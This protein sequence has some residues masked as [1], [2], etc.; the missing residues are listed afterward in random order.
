MRWR[1]TDSRCTRSW[2]T[3]PSSS[4][5]WRALLALAYV[6]L[7]ALARPAA[8]ADARPGRGRRAVRSWRRTSPAT[9]SS[10]AARAAAAAGRVR[11]TEDRA[12]VAARGRASGSRVVA[13]VHGLAA[14]PD[15]GGRGSLLLALLGVSRARHAGHGGAHRRRRRPGGLG[16]VARRRSVRRLAARG[17]Q[18]PERLD[19][20]GVGRAR[21]DRL[22]E[23]ALR[24]VG[25]RG[26]SRAGSPRSSRRGR[27]TPR[28]GA[29]AARGRARRTGCRACR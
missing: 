7:P 3:P 1:S 25:R 11:P 28:S 24:L 27:G 6:S 21:R 15:R 20:L 23:P 17:Q 5:R 18:P 14:H 16:P 10:T 12:R 19:P 26:C 22:V 2:C 29:R 4:A 13:V 9:T 8:L